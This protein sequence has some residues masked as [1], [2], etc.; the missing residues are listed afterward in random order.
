MDDLTLPATGQKIAA[1]DRGDGTF[2][3]EIALTDAAGNTNITPAADENLVLLRRIA[4]T[5]ECLLITDNNQR[6]RV[7]VDATTAFA[8]SANQSVNLTQAGGNNIVT[9]IG[10]G[11]NGVPR[12]SPAIDALPDEKTAQMREAYNNGIR[13]NL[14]FS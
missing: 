13:R 10:S 11:G 9:G 5:L 14:V 7:V 4:K 6:Q 3:Q 2:V 8:L 12:M 1:K